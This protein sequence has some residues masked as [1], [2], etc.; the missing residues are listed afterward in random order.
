MRR[1]T[2]VSR[3]SSAGPG[4]SG[5]RSARASPLP[6]PAGTMPSADAE[7]ISPR[8]TS[9]AVPSPPTD[10]HQLRARRRGRP[11]ELRRVP[12]P[13]GDGQV[14]VVPARMAALGRPARLVARDARPRVQDRADLHA[15][16]RI[17]PSVSST[18]RS[19]VKRSRKQAAPAG[20][21]VGPPPFVAEHL[22]EGPRRAPPDRAGPP[23]GP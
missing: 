14:E 3:A 6:E 16:S 19:A 11:R 23:A 18:M 9:F 13:L 8:A 10:E 2:P 15:T 1:L 4:R 20:A 17:T 21:P 7:P 12:G 5:M 22:G